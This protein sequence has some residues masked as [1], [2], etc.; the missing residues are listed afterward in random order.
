MSGI[1]V[2]GEALV[3]DFIS[4][5]VVGG[6]PFNV[7]RNLA[8]FGQ[9]P[10][11][12]TRIGADKAGA[13]VDGEFERFGMSRQCLQVDPVESTGRVVV[14]RSDGA[15]RFIVLP[16]QAYDHIA[17]A[18]LAAS[19]SLIYFGT[20]AQRSETSRATL[21]QLLG[22]SGACRYLD[23]NVREGQVSERC[24][25]E[26]LREADIV[27]VNEEELQDLF[28]WYTHIR[29]DT[30]DMECSEVRNACAVLMRIFTLEA[31]VVTLGPRGAVCFQRNGTM[32]ASYVTA[33]PRTLVDTV[34][35]GDAFSSVFLLGREL[36]WPLHET[37]MRANEFAG[38][39]CRI[40]GAVPKNLAFYRPWLARWLA[41]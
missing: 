18:P 35:A 30:A 25:Y 11:M 34:G 16:N 2:F 21:R 38:A 26:S 1:V 13:L 3:D 39:I 31:L 5:Q 14:E 33:P 36:G 12:V 27:K 23:L 22:A 28:G 10:L 4:E 37:L 32:S 6:A 41:H 7:A 15:H 9:S 17:P 29:H 24:V 19:A 40:A 20:L 8:A